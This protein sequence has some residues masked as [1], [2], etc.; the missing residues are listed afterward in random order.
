MPWPAVPCAAAPRKVS[1]EPS[2]GF[3]SC[4]ARNSYASGVGR[5]HSISITRTTA[6]PLQLDVLHAQLEAGADA[7]RP[8]LDPLA[9]PLH[10]VGGDE[11]H[12]GQL[13]VQLAAEIEG[14]LVALLV[15]GRGLRLVGHLLQFG[16]VGVRRRAFL[17]ER[18]LEA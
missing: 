1:P 4:A 6:L 9:Q 10:V 8:A 12:V 3:W 17:A 13:L 5:S 16:R 7:R 11:R 18:G 15:A 14:D 2:T